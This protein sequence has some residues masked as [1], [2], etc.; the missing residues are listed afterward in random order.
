MKRR[1]NSLILCVV[2]FF[3]GIFA[4]GMTIEY[5][6][7]IFLDQNKIF[8]IKEILFAIFFSMSDE[9][10]EY[11]NLKNILLF[12]W[13]YL[14]YGLGMIV[15]SRRYLDKEKSY[16]NFIMSRCRDI[17][18]GL[19]YIYSNSIIEK[20]CYVLFF[21]M[22]IFIKSFSTHVWFERDWIF[23]LYIFLFVITKVIQFE[24][25]NLVMFLLYLRY[26][27][28]YAIMAGFIVLTTMILL[29]IF[30]PISL[31]FCDSNQMFVD[32]L[33]I[34]IIILTLLELVR[35]KFKID[36]E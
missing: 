30:L 21:C 24:I 16:Y 12:R 31:F 25:I 5:L 9:C 34:N 36:L 4:A 17:T 15:F 1:V 14:F 6:N 27:V 29:D 7:E 23:F 11:I 10:R 32:T 18:K 13:I 22:G 33:L 19:R 2:A 35:Y 8:T 28:S 20:L 3:I 26:N